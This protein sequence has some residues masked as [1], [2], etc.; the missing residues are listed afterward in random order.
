MTAAG[1]RATYA[2]YLAFEEASEQKHEYV[3]GVIYA[4]TGGISDHALRTD[5]GRTPAHARLAM[6]VGRLLG[7][8][9]ADKPC[10]VFSADARVR[11]VATGRSTYPD[12]SV[13]CTR[14]E[15]AP[16]DPLAITNPILLV[17]VL[18]PTTEASDR[19]D[20][21]HHYQRIPSLQEYVLVGQEPQ[22]VEVYR[23]EGEVWTYRSYDENAQI[24]LASLGVTL[25]LPALY[26]DPLA[27]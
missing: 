26:R 17:E 8:A 16:D 27:G 5:P 19:G 23:R 21:W 9:L 4:I 1:E 18:S 11:V 2:D 24:E 7:N 20:K 14:V 25:D 12:V 13:V 3:D 15:P 10:A 22:Q 6:S